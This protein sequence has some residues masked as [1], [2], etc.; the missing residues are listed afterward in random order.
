[1]DSRQWPSKDMDNSIRGQG[2]VA[3]SET[4][5]SGRFHYTSAFIWAENAE[6][7]ILKASGADIACFPRRAVSASFLS[8]LRAGDAYQ[9]ELWPEQL[10]RSSVKFKWRILSN[11]AVS[12]EGEHVIIHVGQSGRPEPLPE[13]LRADLQLVLP[14]SH[15]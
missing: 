6:H 4:D 3:W 13:L 8:P 11:G 14:P 5:A 15:G 7:A 12:V 2:V 9:V 1:L 10:G